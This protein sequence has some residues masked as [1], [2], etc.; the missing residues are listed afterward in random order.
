MASPLVADL[1]SASLQTH[2]NIALKKLVESDKYQILKVSDQESSR[3]DHESEEFDRFTLTYTILD[4]TFKLS[5]LFDNTN[6]NAP[7]DIIFEDNTGFDKECEKSNILN[8]NT[9]VSQWNINDEYCLMNLIQNIKNIFKEYHLNKALQL[10]IDRI[11]LEINT[12]LSV[13]E[14]FNVMILP[15]EVPVYEKVRFIIPVEKKTPNGNMISINDT[16]DY[17]YGVMLV[18]DFIVDKTTNEVV[19]TSMDYIFSKKTKSIKRINKKL[20]KWETNKYL[21]EYMKETEYALN[22]VILFKTSDGSRKE[23]LTAILNE[24]NEYILEYDSL[25]YSYAAFYIKN[26]QDATDL[27]YNSIILY[28][29]MNEDFPHHEPN[30]SIIIPYHERNQDYSIRH[31][32]KYH[33]NKKF[34][35]ETPKRY[36]EAAALFKNYIISNIPQFI[37]EYKR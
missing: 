34:F 3:I 7:P 13:C 15:Q 5:F 11:D 1:K 26:P 20:P 30:V 21:H 33:F 4:S 24:F 32:I 16:N 12:L 10:S 8:I 37:R 27:Q 23:F 28:F 25:D 35:T 29:S 2:L 18:S 31:N 36:Q 22:D 14:N 17:V 6:P 9:I 19:S